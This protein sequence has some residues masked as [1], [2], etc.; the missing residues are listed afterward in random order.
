MTHN[1]HTKPISNTPSH[2]EMGCF[3]LRT[4]PIY[5]I[6]ILRKIYH[7]IH[8]NINRH[9]TRHIFIYQYLSHK[10]NTDKSCTTLNLTY[11]TNTYTPSYN[12]MGSFFMNHYTHNKK[13]GES[14]SCIHPFTKTFHKNAD[15]IINLYP[16]II[17]HNNMMY[18]LN[19]F[20]I[21]IFPNSKS[22]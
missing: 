22:N 14:F 8:N 9:F 21:P 17:R 12:G 2:Y 4:I 15:L 11:N 1:H 18:S 7:N 6:H 3:F 20:I 10:N 19:K 5:Y 16:Q 13:A